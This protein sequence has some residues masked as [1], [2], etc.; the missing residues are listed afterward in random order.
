MFILKSNIS[1]WGKF[2][3]PLKLNKTLCCHVARKILF[4]ATIF[5]VALINYKVTIKQ[6]IDKTGKEQKCFDIQIILLHFIKNYES[7]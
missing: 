5:I 7:R 4:A 1:K 2:W 6:H 3:I